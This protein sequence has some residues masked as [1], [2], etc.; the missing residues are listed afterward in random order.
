M[1]G[2][3][4]L[5]SD[6]TGTITKNELTIAEAQALGKFEIDDAL[7]Y[8]TLAS[9]EENHDPIDDAVIAKAKSI[10]AVADVLG[11]YSVV[12]FKPFD[13]VL[14]RTEATV[15]SRD[16]GRFKVAKGAPQ[17]VLSLVSNKTEIEDRVNEIVNTFAI[18]GSS[19]VRRN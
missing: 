13:P 18:K 4:V 10:R 19:S 7:L 12:D 11:R 2:V 14:K 15:E 8:G 1:A 9:R 3:D 5:C 16:D 6:K 17:V